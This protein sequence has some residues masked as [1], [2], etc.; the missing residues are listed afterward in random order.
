MNQNVLISGKE[1][2]W[3]NVS[4]W[5]R[6]LKLTKLIFQILKILL[7]VFVDSFSDSTDLSFF[8]LLKYWRYVIFLTLADWFYQSDGEL[9]FPI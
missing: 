2:Q 7:F 9:N 1:D 3:K 8:F 5:K 4:L 6:R